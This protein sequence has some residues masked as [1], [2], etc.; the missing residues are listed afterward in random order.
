MSGAVIFVGPSLERQVVQ[1]I[2]DACDADIT[3]LPPARQ[4]DF[5]RILSE[6]PRIIGLVDGFFFQQPAVHF[7]EI[8]AAIVGGTEVIGASSMGALRAA[9]LRAFGMQGIGEVY[10]MYADDSIDG[11][12]EVA[13]VHTD[14]G[15]D[16]RCLSDALVNIRITVD[17][18]LAEAVLDR[19]TARAILRA[20]KRLHFSQR[21]YNAIFSDVRKL[22]AASFN[23]DRLRAFADFMRTQKI[24]QKRLDAISLVETVVRK[25]HTR[26]PGPEQQPFEL[27][28]TTFLLSYERQYKGR[29]YG[30][31]YL[32]DGRIWALQKLLDRDF[33]MHWR[34]LAVRC[35]AI[36]EA[37][38]RGLTP[39]PYGQ[40]LEEFRSIE[41]LS[42]SDDF[43]EWLQGHSMEQSEFGKWLLET[44]LVNELEVQGRETK[45]DDR[46]ALE[47]LIQLA[48]AKRLGIPSDEII[49]R[50]K[51]R[52][53]DSWDEPMIRH[54]KAS[55]L[56]QSAG[57]RTLEIVDYNRSLE[58]QTPGIIARL[59]PAGL[60][61]WFA[62]RWGVSVSQLRTS[63]LL[64]GFRTL[65]EFYDV[66]R[67]GFFYDALVARP[68]ERQIDR[69]AS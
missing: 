46:E 14:S 69:P 33:E 50:I 22:P 16:Y 43:D 42:T 31:T 13:V 55:G 8:L 21:T 54:Q 44:W 52:P 19:K 34:K 1:S 63:M 36:D 53:G 11:D 56:F 32:P 4:G 20:A 40:L 45:N 59:A 48:A 28:K 67:V 10:R 35:L 18:A 27:P 26:A 23:A 61:S 38:E 3:I 37:R 12:D 57:R 5:L 9:E 17:K 25:L 6:R 39:P 62:A 7:K 51:V 47:A 2:I 68:I 15:D 24:D 41:K 66:A 30:G 60:E 65:S 64:R 49:F 29:W 58:S